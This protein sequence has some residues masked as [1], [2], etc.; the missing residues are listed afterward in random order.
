MSLRRSASR[1]MSLGL[2][3]AATAPLAALPVPRAGIASPGTQAA[4]AAAAAAGL[5]GLTALQ[6]A[7]VAPRQLT[8]EERQQ[9]A[10]EA[11][12]EVRLAGR[13]RLGWLVGRAA[14]AAK[15]AAKP[16]QPASR[17]R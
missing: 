3:P 8:A 13:R 17:C 5:P 7:P 15:L 2:S 4:A 9:L 6:A 1:G 10:R 11:V 12:K 14:P 16:L